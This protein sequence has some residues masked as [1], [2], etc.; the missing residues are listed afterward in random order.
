MSKIRTWITSFAAICAASLTPSIAS[1]PEQLGRVDFIGYIGSL[2]NV[3]EN[4]AIENGYFKKYGLEI[5]IVHAKSSTEMAAALMGGSGQMGML[6]P[7]VTA[8]LDQQGVC[9]KYLAAGVGNYFNIIARKG[10]DLPNLAKGY[11][12]NLVDLKGK[13]VGIV[14]IG[15]P[16]LPWLGSVLAE[17]GLSRDD[18]VYI[19]TGGVA[20]SVAAVQ[21]AQVD[22]LMSYPPVQQVL[23]PEDFV[24]VADLV[25][26]E[27]DPLDALVQS[28]AGTTCEYATQ[29]PKVVKAFCSGVWDAYDYV[30]DP[31]N[32]DGVSQI[33]AKM[34]KIEPDVAA[35]IWKDYHPMFSSP[36]I[37]E[38]RW[39]AQE[40]FMIEK[41]MKMP[42]YSS[43]VEA[44]C[45]N[46]PR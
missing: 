7:S 17:A 13:K 27:G 19:A 25:K 39:L 35:A 10:I 42:D 22:F 18:V 45:V 2:L 38:K 23:D 32:F 30:T 12:A 9:F 20:T 15:G 40:A 4:T 33:I 11:P 34:L 5:N 26:I 36:A 41:D 21:Q 46:D 24:M 29:N 44:V 37:D 31:A 43:R 1:E 3:I 16:A 8:P 6:S 14:A 28:F